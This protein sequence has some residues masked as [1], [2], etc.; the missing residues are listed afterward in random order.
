MDGRE[1]AHGQEE[2]EERKDAE[3]EE[4]KEEEEDWTGLELWE[5]TEVTQ[6]E[7]QT[8]PTPIVQVCWIQ[9]RT[10]CH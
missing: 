2:E 5:S 9:R 10:V 7:N 8:S 4:E 3:E 1:E 6:R